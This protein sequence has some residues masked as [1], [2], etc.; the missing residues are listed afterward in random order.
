MLNNP[1]LVGFNND[2]I[3]HGNQE[4][5]LR[6]KGRLQKLQK[7]VYHSIKMLLGAAVIIIGEEPK[8]EALAHNQDYRYSTNLSEG[9]GKI[10]N[11][12]KEKP[13]A[14]LENG[15]DTIESVE[16]SDSEDDNDEIAEDAQ[17][18]DIEI[19]QAPIVMA[20]RTSH[21]PLMTTQEIDEFKNLL[22][23]LERSGK[24]FEALEMQRNMEGKL[25]IT[26]QDESLKGKLEIVSFAPV[27][28]DAEK[29]SE[30]AR[31]KLS[32]FDEAIK[33]K[34]YDAASDL[35]SG[36]EKMLTGV[37]YMNLRK[38]AQ[39][40]AAVAKAYKVLEND[41][42]NQQAHKTIGEDQILR[43]DKL[44]G[45]SHFEGSKD[46]L[47]RSVYDHRFQ[48]KQSSFSLY[49]NAD[50]IWSRSEKVLNGRKALLQKYALMLFIEAE[51]AGGLTQNMVERISEIKN[52]HPEIL[53]SQ[54]DG[55]SSPEGKM[56]LPA[57]VGLDFNSQADQYLDTGIKHSNEQIQIQ[58][59]IVPHANG[60]QAV[61]SNGFNKGF[62]LKISGGKLRLEICDKKGVKIL[63][64]PPELLK[65]DEPSVVDLV[66]DPS[67]NLA[68]LSLNGT[69]KS[70][71][72]D[73]YIP[74]SD[75]ILVGSRVDKNGRVGY[76]TLK[77]T[78]THVNVTKDSQTEF[79]FDGGNPGNNIS[80]KNTKIE[81]GIMKQLQ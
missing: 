33:Q 10:F 6:K 69:K 2:N 60:L 73:E 22:Q 21:P 8:E 41:P 58:V 20:A 38:Q 40:L 61:V 4:P 68:I 13:G 43:Q 80:S 63:E 12:R 44:E 27:G 72:I 37:K 64:C 65:I 25:G 3:E 15:K 49:T 77:A 30:L 70:L 16:L 57:Q 74:S 81:G 71:Q 28:L 46:S 53:I 18:S 11:L 52:Q 67:K 32:L 23:S 35:A 39:Q 51:K 17:I 76:L 59:R 45:A 55:L 5:A 48:L 56:T 78:V 54:K 24:F 9:L 75:N 34:K 29:K 66:I 79:L 1:N 7:S 42:D 47:L 31:A 36:A 19:A 50:E 62:Q 26:T 14:V